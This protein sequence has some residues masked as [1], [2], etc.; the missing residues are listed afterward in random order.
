MTTTTKTTAGF[1]GSMCGFADAC[2]MV[3]TKRQN[4]DCCS[5]L[6]LDRHIRKTEKNATRKTGVQHSALCDGML[7]FVKQFAS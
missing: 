4:D 6:Q 5:T 7:K 2:R 1:G 3:D